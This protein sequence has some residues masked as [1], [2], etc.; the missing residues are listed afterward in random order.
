L[1]TGC[2]KIQCL[3]LGKEDW[4]ENRTWLPEILPETAVIL[5]NTPSVVE[6][7]RSE[8]A[9]Y[10]SRQSQWQWFAGT[11]VLA[12]EAVMTVGSETH[13]SREEQPVGENAGWS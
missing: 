11:A 8:N 7:M 10:A 4:T 5:T 9:V 12:E 6:L 1:C 3:L 13:Q 2:V